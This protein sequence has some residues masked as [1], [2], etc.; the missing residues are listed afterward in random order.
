MKRPHRLDPDYATEVPMICS[1]GNCNQPIE[2]TA[3][4]RPRTYCSDACRQ[5]EARWRK[6]L[7]RREEAA[8]ERAR[9]MTCPTCTGHGVLRNARPVERH[10]WL[11]APPEFR[12]R[13]PR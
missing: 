4:G 3:V 11:V 7:T 2:Q 10:D 6:E 1:T 5:R 9:W 8:A 13:R 12:D